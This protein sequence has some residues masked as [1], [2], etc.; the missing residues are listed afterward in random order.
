MFL[1]RF[2]LEY[3]L[4]RVLFSL[5]WPLCLWLACVGHVELST[6]PKYRHTNVIATAWKRQHLHVI[7]A[8]VA[9]VAERTLSVPTTQAVDTDTRS[10]QMRSGSTANA[11]SPNIGVAAVC[12]VPFFFS[13][14]ADFELSGTPRSHAVRLNVINLYLTYSRLNTFHKASILKQLKSEEEEEKHTSKYSNR[15]DHRLHSG[16]ERVFFVVFLNFFDWID[17]FKRMRFQTI[18]TS[19]WSH[20]YVKNVRANF[21]KSKLNSKV[22]NNCKTCAKP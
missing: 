2:A 4:A 16:D 12:F 5:A 20:F 9:I 18:T 19:K 22:E 10:N 21:E 11:N 3:Q 14:S 15:V 13:T 8:T 6:Q 1:N 7:A 17:S